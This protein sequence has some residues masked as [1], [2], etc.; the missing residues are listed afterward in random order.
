MR[1]CVLLLAVPLLFPPVADGQLR[2]RARPR[3]GIPTRPQPDVPDPNDPVARSL[4]YQRLRL[5]VESYPQAIAVYAPGFLVARDGWASMGWGARADYRLT[6]QLSAV[7]ESATS[8]VG[9]PIS[10]FT[11]E[12]GA[13]YRPPTTRGRALPFVDMRLGWTSMW[14]RTPTPSTDGVVRVGASASGPGA[15]AGIGMEYMMTPRWS[16]VGGAALAYNAMRA[17][18]NGF[19]GARRQFGMT[20]GRLIAGV[21]Y[22]R[23]RMVLP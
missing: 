5:A 11:L 2:P 10:T 21:R 18:P 4:S 14:E 8:W 3:P 16:A 12:L 19:E 20:T 7:G 23:I 15:M 1:L 22:N 9:S 6:D 17:H 13:R